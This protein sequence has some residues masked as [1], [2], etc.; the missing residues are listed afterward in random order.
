MRCFPRTL[1]NVLTRFLQIALNDFIST[2]VTVDDLRTRL[3]R[4]LK[5]LC[6]ALSRILTHLCRPIFFCIQLHIAPGRLPASPRPNYQ[7]CKIDQLH[8]SYEFGG[9][10][11]SAHRRHDSTDTHNLAC[12]AVPELVNLPKAG[13]SAGPDHRIALYTMLAALVP[14]P[15]VS[16]PLVQ[17]ITILVAKEPH[18]GAAALLAGTLAPHI[19]YLLRTQEGA[20]PA[21][22]VALIAKDMASS[23]PVVR[24]AFI[25]SAGSMFLNDGGVLNTAG[26]VTLGKALLGSF[27]A[28]LKTVTANPLG[29]KWRPIRGVRRAR[30]F[31]RPVRAVQVVRFVLPLSIQMRC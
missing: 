4:R 20:L 13:K 3:H 8:R 26:G 2:F 18:D 29:C 14:A 17:A 12:T 19:A 15:G 28:C 23:K 9:T 22:T 10:L 21:E 25:G 24:R 11:Q 7:Q 31:A 5:K 16:L 6:C 27:E 30:G 1:S